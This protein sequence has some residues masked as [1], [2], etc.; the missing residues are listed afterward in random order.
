MP[1]RHK[2]TEEIWTDARTRW[3]SDSREGYA[4]LVADMA[5]HVT[6]AAVRKKAKKE[7]WRKKVARSG[8]CGCCRNHE[9]VKKS[10]VD[11]ECIPHS[12]ILDRLARALEIVESCATA[13]RET[14]LPGNHR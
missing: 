13:L 9:P 14:M 5:L 3:E 7:G 4:W 8:C 10:S 12:E 1:A 6:G 2:L 11:R